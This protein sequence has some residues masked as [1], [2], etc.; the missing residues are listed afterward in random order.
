MTDPIPLILAIAAAYLLGSLPVGLLMGKAK[1]V[2]IREHGSGNIGATNAMRV[3]GRPLGIACFLLDVAKGALPVVAAGLWLG[4]LGDESL[5][6]ADAFAWFAVGIAS[7][8]GHMFS[9]Y[10][11]FKG[12][13]G[14]ATG[15]GA[16]LGLWPWVTYPAFAAL[17]IWY[18][19]L[20]L[21][22]YVSVSSCVAA[23]SV[24]ISVTTAALIRDDLPGAWPFAVVT[25]ALAALVIWKHRG[26][27]ARVRAGT[28]P[29]TGRRASG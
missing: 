8:L 18:A 16:L 23:L 13:K 10:I 20:K 6:T 21:T 5:P 26:N 1:G 17:F 7:V 9:L 25:A 22:R 14:V 27:L 29:K 12:G 4:Y 15:F 3:L 28:E 24:P 2:D 19:T 11:G